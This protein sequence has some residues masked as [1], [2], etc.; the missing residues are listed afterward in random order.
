[1]DVI[2]PLLVIVSHNNSTCLDCSGIPNGGSEID[3]CGVC[4]G[5]N[6][7]CQDCIDNSSLIVP[8]DC[9]TALETFGCDFVYGTTTGDLGFA[10]NKQQVY[11]AYAELTSEPDCSDDSGC[12]AGAGDANPA[13]CPKPPPYC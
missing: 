7:S 13:S 4:G 11:I 2:Y 6:S 8:F 12:G 10:D 1:M 5:D 9:S 3:N